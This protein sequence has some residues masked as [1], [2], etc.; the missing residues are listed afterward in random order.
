MGGEEM[1]VE[2]LE[3]GRNMG[4]SFRRSFLRSE[5]EDEVEYV[6]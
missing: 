5:F 4:I 1:R 2:F 3:I 6:F